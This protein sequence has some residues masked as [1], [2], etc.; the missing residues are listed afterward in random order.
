MA[1]GFHRHDLGMF[2]KF[3]SRHQ[4]PV[5]DPEP[6]SAAPVTSS[7]AVAGAEILGRV[8]LLRAALRDTGFSLDETAGDVLDVSGDPM[9]AKAVGNWASAR[10]VD[11]VYGH[12][13]L[14]SPEFSS[15]LQTV[16][17]EEE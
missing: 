1:D 3:R 11:E 5:T 6:R 2:A 10:M 13:D 16:W 7:P 8:D 12:P 14:H 9:M 4:R 17:G 15:A